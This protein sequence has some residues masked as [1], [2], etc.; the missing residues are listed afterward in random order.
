M[1]K[2]RFT[3]ENSFCAAAL[4]GLWK[5]RNTLWC[6]GSCWNTGIDP[7][8]ASRM[9]YPLSS[10]EKDAVSNEAISPEGFD[11]RTAEQ[12]MEQVKGRDDACLFK[13]ALDWSSVVTVE[14]HDLLG[15]FKPME[16]DLLQGKWLSFLKMKDEWLM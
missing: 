15:E 12:K 5:L 7:Q 1:S 6:Q 10:T 3:I 4:W 13:M 9:V 8:Y 11:F 16:D 14:A 2:S